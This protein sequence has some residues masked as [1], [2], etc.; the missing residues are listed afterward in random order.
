MRKASTLSTSK[1]TSS[2]VTTYK[3]PGTA[4]SFFD[5]LTTG[6]Q[7]IGQDNGAL[8]ANV[9]TLGYVTLY[10]SSPLSGGVPTVMI[11]YSNG[12]IDKFRFSGGH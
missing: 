11:R 4:Q 3:S 2:E 7:I 8:L 6:L 5:S 10:S 9:P 1:G 12:L